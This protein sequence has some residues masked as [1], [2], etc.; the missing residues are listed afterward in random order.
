M[1]SLLAS[2]LSIPVLEAYACVG[3][4]TPHRRLSHDAE[5]EDPHLIR[6]DCPPL[7]GSSRYWARDYCEVKKLL[8]EKH[9]IVLDLTEIEH[10]DSRGLAG[11]VGLFTWA[12]SEKCEIRLVDT[13]GHVTDL[14]RRTRLHKI[15]AVRKP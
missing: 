3:C 4:G 14:L 11:L 13:G 6:R 7:L 9:R 5:D 2:S 10:I 1:T 12:S 8:S 15:L